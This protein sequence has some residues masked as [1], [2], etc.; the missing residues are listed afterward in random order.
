MLLRASLE[1]L[2]P[3]I[4]IVAVNIIILVIILVQR[5]DIL[6]HLDRMSNTILFMNAN[7]TATFISALLPNSYIIS[8]FSSHKVN[9][10]VLSGSF[11]FS[12]LWLC[13]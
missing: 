3:C 8:R 10:E 5:E 11:F 13:N 9:E 4:I 7:C 12:S 2:F 6:T 1:E